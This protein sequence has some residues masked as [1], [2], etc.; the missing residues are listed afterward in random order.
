[1]SFEEYLQKQK[2][3]SSTIQGHLAD[4]K[5]FKNWCI[6]EGVNHNQA[7]YNHLLKFID[8]FKSREI[9]ATTIN[10]HLNSISKYYN[11]QIQQERRKACG[12]RS[13]TNNPARDLRVK[14]DGS[15]VLRDLLSTAQLDQIYQ[16][17]SNKPTWSF[18]EEKQ[19]QTHRRN[20]VILGLLIYQ[21]LQTGELKK[22]EAHHI[23]LKTGTIYIPTGSRGNS[24]TLKLQASQILAIQQYIQQRDQFFP[25]KRADMLFIGNMHSIIRW[26]IGELRSSN[27]LVKSAFQIRSSVIVNWLS[28][29][30]LR[31]VQYMAGH[32]HIGSTERY[33]QE[34]LGDL[35]RQLEL[36]HPLGNEAH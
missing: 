32:R 8:Q 28:R 20:T 9:T 36:F 10:L 21:G 19:K 2:L 14:K 6:T 4:I 23:N 13:R 18:R 35:Q 11:Y 25:A 26:L 7:N 34:D 33:K 24:R 3:A 1:M 22:L 12:E 17:Y 30:N 16:Q 15:K 27:E 31:Q 29:H 5:R